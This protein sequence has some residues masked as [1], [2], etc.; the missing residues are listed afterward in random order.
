MAM[1]MSRY[2]TMCFSPGR[3]LNVIHCSIQ[4]ARSGIEST[5]CSRVRML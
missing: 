2:C 1:M 5:F 3:S 4:G